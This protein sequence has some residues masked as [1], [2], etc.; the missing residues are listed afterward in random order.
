MVKGES[1]R[2]EL[3]KKNIRHGFHGLTRPA[4]HPA[5]AGRKI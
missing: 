1:E 2:K 3:K 5:G 4:F